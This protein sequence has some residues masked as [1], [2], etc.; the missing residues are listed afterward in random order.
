MKLPE[1]SLP[2]AGDRLN[3]ADEI[4]SA[5]ERLFI[6]IA[7]AFDDEGFQ[8]SVRATNADMYK[9]RRYESALIPDLDSEFQALSECWKARDLPRLRMLLAAYFERREQLS[10]AIQKLINRPN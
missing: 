7:D 1:P 3:G 8:R 5:T 6:E 10:P 9:V 4:T 2:G